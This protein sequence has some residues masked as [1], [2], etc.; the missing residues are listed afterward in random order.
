MTS[1]IYKITNKIN[2][3]SYIGSSKNIEKRWN[4]HIRN[5]NNPNSKEYEYPI[6]RAI[7]KYKINNFSFEI[8]EA[9]QT[10]DQ[11]ILLEREQYYYDLYSPEYNQMR[12]DFVPTYNPSEEERKERSIKYSGDGNPFYGKT[13]SKETKEKLS[14]YAKARIGELNPFYGKHHSS[15]TKEK[16]A[17]ANGKEVIAT[18]LNGKEHFFFSAKEAGEWCRELGLTKSKT[19]NSDI[20]KVCKGI[21]NKA[22]GFYWRYK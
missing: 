15:E 18:D 19:P 13:H 14:K 4:K 11:S 2:N 6:Y 22:F 12:P 17:R 10:D 20:L 1:G 9:L 8:I 3:N 21:K 7:R 16:L 5:S